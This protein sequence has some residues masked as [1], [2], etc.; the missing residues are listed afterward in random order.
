M[1]NN[2]QQKILGILGGGQL[3][4]M[5]IQSAISY[6]IDIHILDPDSNAPCK[7][8]CQKFTQGSLADFETVYAFGKDCDIITIE[9]ENVNTEALEKLQ[10][11]GKEV[12]PQPHLIRLIQDKRLQKTFYKE[13]SI[14][15]APFVLTENKQAVINQ[16][17]F[18][19]AVNKLGREGYDG[20]GVQILR[21]EEDLENAFDKPGLLEKLIDFDK[22]IAVIVAKNKRGDIISYPS[23]ECAFHPTANL[24]EFLF[25]PAEIPVEV[26]NKAQEIAKSVIQKLDL[27]GILAVELFVTKA[28]EILV[29][30]IA[31]RPHNSGHHSIEANITSQFEQHLRAVLNMPLGNT[32]L[33]SPAAM[34]NLLGEDGY[35]GEVYVE[36]MDEALKQKGVYIHLY[37][38][39][40]TKPF[41][42]MGHVTILDEDLENL[43]ERAQEI[44]NMIKIKA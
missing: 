34:V 8:I 18:L 44:K 11:E 26:E 19:P 6:N 37:G 13:N 5:L 40:I 21:K 38:K 9:I 7:S 1:Q 42:K 31:P 29:N 32:T 22:E 39:K 10:E 12:F 43:K 25:A 24:V 27:V 30:E 23:V 35:Q 33:R 20:R 14:P 3:G 17:A 41:R 28:G 2:Y 4:R 36:G 16:T 15:T